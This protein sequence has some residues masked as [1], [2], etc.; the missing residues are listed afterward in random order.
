MK[1]RVGKLILLAPLSC[2]LMLGALWFAEPAAAQDSK[3]PAASSTLQ[4]ETP[5]AFAVCGLLALMAG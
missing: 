4:S 5:A 2:V 3:P 1:E